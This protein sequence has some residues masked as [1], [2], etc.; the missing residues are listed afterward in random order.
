MGPADIPANKK[1]KDGFGIYSYSWGNKQND[2]S[3]IEVGK[4]IASN[5]YLIMA[6]SIGTVIFELTGFLLL[7]KGWPKSLY[8]S[9]AIAMHMTIGFLMDL[10]FLKFQLLAL[11]LINWKWVYYKVT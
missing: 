4:T 8:L 5:K 9:G 2:V 3:R 6:L 7:T 10:Q 11:L 1:W